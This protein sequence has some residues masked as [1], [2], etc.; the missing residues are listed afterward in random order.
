M[1]SL[2]KGNYVSQAKDDRQWWP[3]AREV[4]VDVLTAFA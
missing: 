4:V 2:A 3:A 1:V